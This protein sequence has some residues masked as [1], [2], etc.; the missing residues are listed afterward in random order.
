MMYVPCDP[1]SPE[2]WAT[3]LAS[4]PKYLLIASY[5]ENAILQEAI[6]DDALAPSARDLSKIYHVNIATANRSIHMLQDRGF[7]RRMPGIGMYIL[8][9]SRTRLLDARR[10]DFVAN[11]IEPCVAEA[12]LLGLSRTELTTL[13]AEAY[14]A[15][16]A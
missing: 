9:G 14:S 5:I 10:E 13:L 15:E 1:D 7:L 2:P 12:K 4:L 6:P 8:A 3:G 11:H 16:D